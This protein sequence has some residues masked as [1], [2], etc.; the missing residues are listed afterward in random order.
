M[1]R[2]L[3][4]LALLGAASTA[5]AQRPPQIT[6]PK[7]VATKA[8]ANMFPP[9]RQ[10]RTDG[11]TVEFDDWWFNL[12]PSNTEPLLR[13]NVEARDPELGQ[14]KRDEILAVIRER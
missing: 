7:E 6:R 4:I 3:A 1:I 13:L 10:D 12:R 9:E 8:V 11:L 14:A 2:T 5:D